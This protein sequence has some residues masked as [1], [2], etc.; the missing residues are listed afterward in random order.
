MSATGASNTLRSDTKAA[1]DVIN[2]E[3]FRALG[4][5]VRIRVLELL[6]AREE[7]SVREL[8]G[9]AQI[10]PGAASQHLGAMRRQRLLAARRQGTSVFYRVRDPRAFRLLDL[11]RE[12]MTSQ[13]RYSQTL[14]EGLNDQRPTRYTDA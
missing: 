12:L 5:P 7:M 14:L 4:H 13:A 9:A 3:L 2:A 1:V 8:R 6:R 11:A 10:E